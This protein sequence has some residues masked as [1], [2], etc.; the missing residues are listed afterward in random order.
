MCGNDLPNDSCLRRHLFPGLVF[1]PVVDVLGKLDV[2]R[3]VLHLVAVLLRT[4]HA[5]NKFFIFLLVVYVCSAMK[6]N[7]IGT[8]TANVPVNVPVE[9]KEM[10]DEL[11][12]KSGV[13]VSDYLRGII[14]CAIESEA[15]VTIHTSKRPR[16]N[17][18]EYKVSMHPAIKTECT[19][20]FSRD[21]A[22]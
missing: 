3:N 22:K 19:H 14:T 2:Y 7:P 1:K 12:S 20:N 11:A 9:M 6:T 13:T 15:L 8:G 21:Y 10:L 18:V 16:R 5:S 4:C 17:T